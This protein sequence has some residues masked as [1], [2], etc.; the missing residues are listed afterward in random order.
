MNGI[1]PRF[2][3]P[4]STYRFRSLYPVWTGGTGAGPVVNPRPWFGGGEVV[5]S[6]NGVSILAA[7]MGILAGTDQWYGRPEQAR[8]G[9]VTKKDMGVDI[10]DDRAG[11]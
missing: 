10:L 5:H 2:T 6:A 1:Y 11:I 4:D 7:V 3:G 9:R 8:L